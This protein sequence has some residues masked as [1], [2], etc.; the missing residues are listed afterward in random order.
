[1]QAI[2]SRY[3]Y[4]DFC[5]EIKP[6]SQSVGNNNR[7]RKKLG[8]LLSKMNWKEMLMETNT[9]S[10]TEM[11]MEMETEKGIKLQIKIW[12]KNNPKKILNKSNYVKKYLIKKQNL[13]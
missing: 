3:T 1:M 2:L 7:E 8:T 6:N 11:E 13:F 10:E 12:R 9:E 4:L 5:N